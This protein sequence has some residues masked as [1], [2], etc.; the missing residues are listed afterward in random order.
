MDYYPI[1]N[2]SYGML[3]E[4][5]YANAQG[6]SVLVSDTNTYADIYVARVRSGGLPDGVYTVKQS[7]SAPSY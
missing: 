4:K 5:V 3:N 2:N 6:T 7:T 1:L